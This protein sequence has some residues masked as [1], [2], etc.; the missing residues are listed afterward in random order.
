MSGLPPVFGAAHI[1]LARLPVRMIDLGQKIKYNGFKYEE[2]PRA[3]GN[4]MGTALE[5][6]KP[7]RTAHILLVSPR[8]TSPGCRHAWQ[9]S[10]KMQH[11]HGAQSLKSKFKVAG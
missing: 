8:R 7:K 1:R 11:T 4:Q 9:S 10:S 2:Q 6:E 5:K 3:D